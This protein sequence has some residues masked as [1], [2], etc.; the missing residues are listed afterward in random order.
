MNIN[1]SNKMN[2]SCVQK[3]FTVK[4]ECTIMKAKICNK[5]IRI[6]LFY[7]V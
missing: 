7:E 4:L 6:N 2:L 1:I 5:I 3:F